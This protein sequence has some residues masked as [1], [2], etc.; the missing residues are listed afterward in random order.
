[1][2]CPKLRAGD[3]RA[4]VAGKPVHFGNCQPAVLLSWEGDVADLL[5]FSV[6]SP[7]GSC[8]PALRVPFCEDPSPDTW[9]WADL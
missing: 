8:I 4:G 1:M 5:L 7:T 6:G 3:G 9:H 2:G